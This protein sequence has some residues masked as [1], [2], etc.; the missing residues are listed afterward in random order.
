MEAL[1]LRL[2]V[3]P[4]LEV[5]WVLGCS[6]TCWSCSTH[7]FLELWTKQTRGHQRHHWNFGSVIRSLWLVISH[8]THEIVVW[9]LRWHCSHFYSIS[10]MVSMALF[11]VRC[12]SILLWTVK[13][14]YFHENSRIC[15]ASYYKYST[16]SPLLLLQ[17]FP[18]PLASRRATV[19]SLQFAGRISPSCLI[20]ENIKVLC[21]NFKM[22][23]TRKRRPKPWKNIIN[24]ISTKYCNKEKREKI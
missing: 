1:H 3:S 19:Q 7:R 17:S 21:S 20:Y 24:T 22:E 15:V 4:T 23:S 10:Q 11:K 9:L 13:L 18:L 2:H 12:W 14:E 6:F 16:I 8:S 5:I